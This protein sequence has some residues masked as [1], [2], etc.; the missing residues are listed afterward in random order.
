MNVHKMARLTPHRRG[1][2]VAVVREGVAITVVAQQVAVSRQT[3]YKWMRR[4]RAEGPPGLRDRSSRPRRCPRR[5]A[6]R[7]RRQVERLRRRRRSS[8]WIARELRLPLSTV[9]AVYFEEASA[10]WDLAAPLH[11]LVGIGRRPCFR[12]SVQA[13]RRALIRATLVK[14][15]G[16]RPARS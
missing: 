11:T 5:L 3:V 8:V 16:T 2:L 13:S 4:W 15:A 7:Q 1:E 6:W 10:Y 12:A 9:V 14:G